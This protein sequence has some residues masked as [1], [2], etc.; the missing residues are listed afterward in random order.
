MK[1][2]RVKI[3]SLLLVGIFCC[4]ILGSLNLNISSAALNSSNRF[5]DVSTAQINQYVSDLNITWG[6]D[7]EDYSRA[8]T[9][10]N[11]GN[12]YITGDT[13][14]FGAGNYDVFTAK[15]DNS[16]N[17]LW[18]TT[19]GGSSVETGR[20]IALDQLG[21]V[22]ITGETSSF[23]AGS[24][25]AFI[26]KYDNSGNFQW[27]ITWGGVSQDEAYDI[28]SDNLGNVFIT[29]RTQ[30][31]GAGENDVF[32]VKFDNSS[33]FLWNKTWGGINSEIGK[34]I[35]SDD[36]GNIYITG[37]TRSF[38]AGDWDAF[39]VKY[40]NLGIFQWD[41]TW[42]GS[43]SDSGYDIALDELGNL[44]I[45]GITSSYGAGNQDVFIVKYNSSGIVQWDDT[46]GDTDSDR[47]LG[48]SLDNFRNIYVTGE[49]FIPGGEDFD[50][51]ILKYNNSGNLLWNN[52]WDNGGSDMPRDIAVD[53]S[54]NIYITGYI[55]KSSSSNFDAF[56][57]RFIDS[58]WTGSPIRIITPENRTYTAPMSG[59]Y[60]ATYGFENDLD[61]SFPIGWID[62]DGTNCATTV[63][64]SHGGH[65]QVIQFIDAG[66][67]VGQ[68]CMISNY[69]EVSQTS[70]TVEWWWRYEPGGTGACLGFQLF[71]DLGQESIYILIDWYD[72][73]KFELEHNSH[74]EFAPGLYSDGTW[75]HMRVDFECGSGNYMGLAADTFNVY[76]NG[77]QYL[78]GEPFW[79]TATNF[80][81]LRLLNPVSAETGEGYFD[82]ISYSWDPNYN[83]G[84]NMNEG[85]LLSYENSTVLDWMGYSLDGAANITIQGNTTIPMPTGNGLHSIQVFGTTTNRF[86]FQSDKRYFSLDWEYI[87]L[88]PNLNIL[89]MIDEHGM[90]IEIEL[91]SIGYLRVS[92]ASSEIPI[93]SDPGY[94]TS[95]LYTYIIDLYSANLVKDSSILSSVT[96]RFYY[97]PLKIHNPLNLWVSHRVS[98]LGL[99]RD[100]DFSLNSTHH[101][102]EFTTTELSTFLM[103]ETVNPITPFPWYI[104]III[105]IL[106]TIGITLTTGYVTISRKKKKKEGA[107][108]PLEQKV[109][110]TSELSTLQD[111]ESRQE[112]RVKPQITP[113]MLTP[114]K[115]LESKV[116]Q[117]AK[118]PK[119]LSKKKKQKVEEKVTIQEKALKKKELEKTE[120]EIDIIK[121]EDK[122]VIHKGEIKGINYVCPKCKAKYCLKCASTL[123]RRGESCWI[124]DS[125]ITM[126]IE[127]SNK[128]KIE[129]EKINF[130]NLINSSNPIEELLKHGDIEMTAIPNEIKRKLDKLNLDKN[131]LDE[132]LKD[133]VVFNT[134]EQLKI[135]E[136]MLE[137]KNSKKIDKQS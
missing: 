19:W 65:E 118:P 131:E 20:G 102:V 101:Y 70:G 75:F 134:Q 107:F 25:D 87:C 10:D 7:N 72:N 22:Y 62:Q 64:A 78:S 128:V 39:I 40:N 69:F 51:F 79:R 58:N 73:G 43:N 116:I 6:G 89:D 74:I 48:L 41:L 33:N 129:D 13:T 85:L 108:K 137:M 76:V 12:I 86:I 35:D 42:G 1:S 66:A 28:I 68:R 121:Q 37:D 30:S 57:M 9:L 104:I 46:W 80:N 32:I 77:V 90:Y 122:C 98:D 15:Y 67:V 55:R 95:T 92:N 53:A 111:E 8:I 136:G 50:N 16:G 31:F 59:Y 61:G 105:I 124:C 14:S 56:I 126:D 112:K 71:N 88:R 2:T 84:D 113:D 3:K 23:G 11:S 93:I 27:E 26:V 24:W 18:N 63:K 110:L 109:P 34:R 5:I 47:G 106:S 100:V 133:L 135:I 91:N 117:K 81:R 97:D 82:A 45:V 99:W 132:I 54:E 44:Y 49:R 120:K 115:P 114:I 119:S 52:T 94:D 83:I 21:N 4:V 125:N 123:M 38:G 36:F 130:N 17:L 103:S 29:G 60:P 96:I 127:S